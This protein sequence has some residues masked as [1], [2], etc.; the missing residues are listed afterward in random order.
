MGLFDFF[1]RKKKVEKRRAEPAP[2]LAD[3]NKFTVI[4]IDV[5]AEG[6]G[7][8]THKYYG[9]GPTVWWYTNGPGTHQGEVRARTAAQANA[10]IIQKTGL[11]Y[12]TFEVDESE[13]RATRRRRTR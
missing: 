7:V 9:P 12:A 13:S 3:K 10:K 5:D 11:S 6:Y 8:L 1:K 4:R 2:A